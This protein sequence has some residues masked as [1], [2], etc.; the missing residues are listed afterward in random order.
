MVR[1]K[2]L[3]RGLRRTF[4]TFLEK[5]V[6]VE[7]PTVRP[8]VDPRARGAFAFAPEKCI[9]CELCVRAC[10]NKAI[11]L[12]WEKG[13]G[14]GDGEGTVAAKRRLTS[15]RLEP[16]LCLFCGLCAEACPTKAIATDPRYE[17]ATRKREE[18]ALVDYRRP[19]GPSPGEAPEGTPGEVKPE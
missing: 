13:E 12:G 11:Q 2:G 4:R 8:S 9:A 1:G 3:A 7:Y 6:T 18:A 10:P 16:G 15:Y 5:P 19:P 17:L 14:K